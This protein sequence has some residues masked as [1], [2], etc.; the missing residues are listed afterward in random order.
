[1]GNTITKFEFG[2]EYSVVRQQDFGQ[3]FAVKFS[4][5]P[6]IPSLIR[7]SLFGGK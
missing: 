2:V 7:N 5:I 4:V 3:R 1:M 6:V